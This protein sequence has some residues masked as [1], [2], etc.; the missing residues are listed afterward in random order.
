MSLEGRLF[1]EEIRAIIIHD[2]EDI[3]RALA[4]LREAGIDAVVG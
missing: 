4:I 3:I 1:T 2:P